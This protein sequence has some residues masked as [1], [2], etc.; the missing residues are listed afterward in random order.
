MRRFNAL[1]ALAWLVAAG[2]AVA[3]PTNMLRQPALSNDHLAF[4]YAGDL[5]LADRDGSHPRRLTSHAASEFAPRFS[6]DGRRIA[7]SASY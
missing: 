2:Q 3:E 1:M 7:F 6:P 4:V 5:W